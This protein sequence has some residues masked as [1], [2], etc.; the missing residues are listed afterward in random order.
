MIIRRRFLRDRA[1]GRQIVVLDAAADGVC[2][3]FLGEGADEIVSMAQ[4]E[5]TQADHT[6]K[7]ASVWK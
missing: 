2:Q 6:L 1:N 4:Q 5:R 7:P 3:E